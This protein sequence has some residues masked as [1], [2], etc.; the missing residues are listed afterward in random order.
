MMGT[1]IKAMIPVV[2]ML[3]IFGFTV[4]AV[5]RQAREVRQTLPQSLGELTAA[6]LIEVRD[7]GGQTVLTGTLTFADERDGE[8]EGEA[9]L[10]GAGA[11]AGASGKAEVEVSAEKGGARS[12]EIELEARGL[13]PGASYTLHLDGR[14]AGAFNTDARGAAEFEWSSEPRR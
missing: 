11:A 5:T 12:Q 2:G 6:R 3:L 8:V 9:N 14:Q 10:T 7:A 4:V 13:A 1:R